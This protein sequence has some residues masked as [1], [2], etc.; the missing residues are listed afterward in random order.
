LLTELAT[1]SASTSSRTPLAQELAVRVV[2]VDHAA[3]TVVHIDLR[4]TRM[5]A[6]AGR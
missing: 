3:P 6:M 2:P 5:P 1:R 4:P